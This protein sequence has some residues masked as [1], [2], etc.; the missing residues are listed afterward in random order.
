VKYTLF[1]LGGLLALALIA[2][3]GFVATFDPNRYKDEAEQAV[4]DATGRELTIAGELELE[5]FPWLALRTG[6]VV[7]GNAPGFIGPFL[8]LE[9]A[10][11]KVKVLPLLRGEVE[12]GE[13]MLEGAALRLAVD[14]AGRDNWSDL[15]GADGE[16]DAA[17][18]ARGAGPRVTISGVAVSGATLEYRDARDGSA[19]TVSELGLRT[20]AIEPGSPLTVA[21]EMR[22]AVAGVAAGT[23][24]EGRLRYAA[25]IIMGRAVR[26]TNLEL[27]LDA[28]GGPLPAPLEGARFAAK[29]L[30]FGERIEFEDVHIAAWGLELAGALE[31]VDAVGG[32]RTTGKLELAPFAPREVLPRFGVALPVTADPKAIASVAGSIAVDHQG[33]RLA[34][35]GL[36]LRVDQSTLT[37]RITLESIARRSIR[38]ELALDAFDADRYLPPPADAAAPVEVGGLDAVALN[39]DWLRGLDLVGTLRAGKLAVARFDLADLRVGID[40]REGRLWIKPLGAALYGGK[41]QGEIVVDA[42]GAVPAGRLVLSLAGIKLHDLLLDAFASK[43]VS[44]VASVDLDLAGSGATVGAL[45]R[46][47]D[48]TIRF[49]VQDGALES[50]SVWKQARIAWAK[51]KSRETSAASEPDRTE[52]EEFTGGAKVV[53]G[54]AT[55]EGVRAAIRFAEATAKGRIDLGKG[56]LKVTAEAKVHEAPDFGPGENLKDLKGVTLPVEISGPF[57]KPKVDVD[58]VKAATSMIKPDVLKDQ[59]LRKKLKGLFG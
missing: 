6:R 40:A 42:R 31:R 46:D 50:F 15:R 45:K 9:G 23:P 41:V 53:D 21:G 49:A 11:A 29:Q 14:T 51:Y 44:G 2:V 5:L 25:T 52:F 13:L 48:G 38:F 1:V 47:L 34:L 27:G 10:R 17:G 19:V 37:G 8:T 32:A 36:K 35:E 54:V 28:E 3:V 59:K 30:A 26:I 55:L 56:T 18:D 20:S 24:L 58:M 33:D 22:F 57:A 4:E 43:L 7:L 12:I 16:A 39:V